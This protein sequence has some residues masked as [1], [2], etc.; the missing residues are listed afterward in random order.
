MAQRGNYRQDYEL[1]LQRRFFDA[2][3]A[4]DTPL[5]TFA[6]DAGVYRQ[7]YVDMRQDLRHGLTDCKHR[8]DAAALAHICVKYGVSGHWLLTGKGTM[9]E[10]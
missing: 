1:G 8:L 5:S 6:A 7:K 10:N 2:L 3:A 9:Y 4:T